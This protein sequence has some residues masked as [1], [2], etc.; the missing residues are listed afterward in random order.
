MLIK[1]MDFI[2]I[3]ISIFSLAISIGTFWLVFIQRG[4]LKMIKPTVVFLGYDHTPTPTA[5]IF[6]R[7]LLYSTAPRGVVIEGMYAKIHSKK[8]S[9]VFYVWGYGER[10]KLVQGSRLY[11]GQSG[12]SANHHFVSSV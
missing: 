2:S 12:F 7:T 10:E 1:S 11:I 5:K 4:R 3:P 6:I 9:D 8:Q